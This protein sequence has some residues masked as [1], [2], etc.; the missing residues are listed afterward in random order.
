[1]DKLT[2]VTQAAKVTVVTRRM[3]QRWLANN[4]PN[5]RPISQSTIDAYARDM[6]AGAWDLNG[7]SIK[8]D[9]EGRLFDGQQRMLALLQS[10]Q[11]SITVVVVSGLD[12]TA[13]RTVDIG[14]PRRFADQLRIEESVQIGVVA[15]VVRRCMY[16]EGGY[17]ATMKHAPRLSHPEMLTR[18]RKDPEQFIEAGRRGQD[19]A[20]ARLGPAWVPGLLYFLVHQLDTESTHIFFDHLMSGANLPEASPILTLRGRLH[21]LPART[22]RY[23]AVE[24]LYIY[25]LAWNA[26]RNDETVYQF[27][28]FR[29]LTND[30]FPVPR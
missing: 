12:P 17:R 9:R 22:E 29:G 16:W 6:D 28:R 2:V 26:W 18:Y 21:E 24:K 19:A 8:L 4:I 7:E 14:R 25:I 3:A 15:A 11:P 10:S 20:R 13:V 5:N 1:M 30:K 27:R 23:S